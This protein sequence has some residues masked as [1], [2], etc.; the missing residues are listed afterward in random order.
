METKILRKTAVPRLLGLEFLLN[1]IATITSLSRNAV[2]MPFDEVPLDCIYY[3]QGTTDGGVTPGSSDSSDRCR[4]IVHAAVLRTI[5][6]H[7]RRDQAR[8]ATEHPWNK[9][10]AKKPD[11]VMSQA[12]PDV[13]QPGR[14]NAAAG[15]A[16]GK[17]V[18]LISHVSLK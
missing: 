14:P 3:R 6:V 9:D 17:S 12:P 11:I 7:E 13:T 5:K 15:E 16:D 1:F 8:E 18:D 2:M 4:A 10:T